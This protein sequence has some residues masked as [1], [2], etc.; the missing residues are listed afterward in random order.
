MSEVGERINGGAVIDERSPETVVILC[1]HQRGLRARRREVLTISRTM[2]IR[3][4]ALLGRPG[5]NTLREKHRGG[6]G[7]EGEGAM[8]TCVI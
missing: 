4:A 2:P 1:V 7:R 3:C 8:L 5:S 6:R